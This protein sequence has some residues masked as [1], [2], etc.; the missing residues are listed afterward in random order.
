MSVFRSVATSR[1]LSVVHSGHESAPA[2]DARAP[3]R[4]ALGVPPL[5]SI[6]MP[7]YNG[8]RFLRAA[9]QSILEQS[10]SDFE[11]IISDNASTD[12]TAAICREFAAADPR[13][14]YHRQPHNIGGAANFNFLLA[15]ARGR[16]FK[17]AAC[18]DVCQPSL[19]QLCLNALERDRGAVLSFSHVDKIGEDGGNLGPFTRDL[20]V[21]G[22]APC[23]RFARQLRMPGWCVPTQVY[24]MVRT[25]SLRRAG[26]LGNFPGAD[27]VLFAALALE[28]AFVEIP[29]VLA[30]RRI[31]ADNSD[32]LYKSDVDLAI[33]WFGAAARG[34]SMP[35]LRRSRE[36][37]RAIGRAPLSPWQ[38]GACLGL[39]A[40]KLLFAPGAALGR[41]MMLRDA[42]VL[43]R[44]RL[45]RAEAPPPLAPRA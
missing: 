35:K 32:V 2:T 28:G 24:A 6:G 14:R 29:E 5:I 12:G 42:L 27:L 10:L 16:Y 41:R 7:V 18:D 39:L 44:R 40:N 20:G 1:P 9:L 37:L 19:L 22:A 30:F 21:P 25:A 38:K 15:Q 8:E 23:A 34:K 26:G 13:I 4:D 17:W 3:A 11:L 33:G 36:Y 31:H 43:V 45:L